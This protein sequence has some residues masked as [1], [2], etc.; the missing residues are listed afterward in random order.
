LTQANSIHFPIHAFLAESVLKIWQNRR[1]LI[2]E[3][4][5]PLNKRD[6]KHGFLCLGCILEHLVYVLAYSYYVEKNIDPF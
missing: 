4:S 3:S 6:N 2:S 5:I 1:S